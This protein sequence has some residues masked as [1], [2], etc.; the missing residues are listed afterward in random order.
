MGAR[1][2]RPKPTEQK[3]RTGNPGK[4]PL[5]KAGSLAAVPA[6]PAGSRDISV[7]VAMERVLEHGYWLAESDAPM[8]ALFREATEDYARLRDSGAASAK[9]VRDART[10]VA[11][12]AGLLGFDPTSRSALGLAEV[13]ARSKLESIQ[14]KAAG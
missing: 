10:E 5:P 12:L 2:P 14:R 4:R 13:T 8:V 7:E 3:R 11:R 1:G 9:E 6:I